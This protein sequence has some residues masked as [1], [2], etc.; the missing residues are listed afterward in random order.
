VGKQVVTIFWDSQGILLMNWLYTGVTI[1]SDRYC[2]TLTRLVQNPS[3]MQGKMVMYSNAAA[4][5]YAT[6]YQWQK[7]VWH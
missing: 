1:N 7:P 6:T 5:Q 2:E 3:A 4:W